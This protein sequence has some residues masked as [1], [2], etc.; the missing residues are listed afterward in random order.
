MVLLKFV[1]QHIVSKKATQREATIMHIIQKYNNI[2]SDHLFWLFIK[3]AVFLY[4]LLL[5]FSMLT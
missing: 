3:S 2:F 1:Y 4:S 5:Y